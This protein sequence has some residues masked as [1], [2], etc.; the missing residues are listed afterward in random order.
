M[1]LVLLPLLYVPLLDGAG[2]V[3]PIGE[4]VKSLVLGNKVFSVFKPMW[5]YGCLRREFEAFNL[6][7]PDV[8]GILLEYVVLDEEYWAL[9]LNNLTFIEVSILTVAGVMHGTLFMDCLII[10]SGQANTS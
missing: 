9:M 8:P 10:S 5:R 6:A 4:Q 1:S 7:N 2:V 3:T